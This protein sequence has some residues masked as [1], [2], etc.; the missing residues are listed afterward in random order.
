M[1]RIA[2]WL[3]KVFLSVSVVLT[4]ALGALA[5]ISYVAP[6]TFF[7]IVSQPMAGLFIEPYYERRVTSF[8]AFPP[9]AG[10]IVFVGDSITEGGHWHDMFPGQQLV[11]FGVGGDTTGGVLGRLFQVTRL[12]P[13]RA[14]LLIGTNDL[15]MG[16][17]LE[18][19]KANYDEILRRFRAESPGTLVHVQSVLPRSRPYAKHV[20]AL[21]DV[22][23]RLS[24]QH[25]VT[26][27]DLYPHFA[28]DDGSLD[29]RFS[30]D[31]LHL[32][33]A[34]YARWRSLIEPFVVAD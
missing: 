23:R 20:Q 12:G 29:P 24:E 6:V 18:E 13:E 34:G 11:N 19:I 3:W 25:G 1:W 9:R 10:G 26:Y 27:I 4:L 2:K 30:N 14:F 8:E 16:L 31:S 7:A 15:G 21:N 5:A 33:G 32:G 17:P 28:S 22:I